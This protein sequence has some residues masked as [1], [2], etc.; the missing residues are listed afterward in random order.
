MGVTIDRDLA[1]V[2]TAGMLNSLGI[3]LAVYVP[4]H[5]ATGSDVR[6]E[7]QLFTQQVSA[8]W[9][10]LW[11][12]QAESGG[13]WGMWPVPS[14]RH[15][16]RTSRLAHIVG[17]GNWAEPVWIVH[18]HT[19]IVIQEENNSWLELKSYFSSSSSPIIYITEYSLSIRFSCWMMKGVL[20]S[21]YN[22]FDALISKDLTGSTKLNMYTNYLSI[23]LYYY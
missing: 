3:K 13:R 5:C 14:F 11:G 18:K 21:V 15:A 20:K 17:L 4:Y 1:L 19:H 6:R 10:R 7:T 2:D 22:Y 12:M 16:S 8:G 9:Q 23:Q